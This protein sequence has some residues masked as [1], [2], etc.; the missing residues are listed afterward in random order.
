MTFFNINNPFIQAPNTS[1][2]IT[3]L[4]KT[5]I[6]YPLLF[7][8]VFRHVTKTRVPLYY[9]LIFGIVLIFLQP[10]LFLN[11]IL[12]TVVSALGIF[13]FN[14]PNEERFSTVVAQFGFS[15]VVYYF[16]SFVGLVG[17][18][19]VIT[20][21][22][23]F[24]ALLFFFLVPII[25]LIA[26][27]IIQLSRRFFVPYF[28]IVF[29]QYSGLKYLLSLLFVPLSYFFY[30][31][32]YN[33]AMI[34]GALHV[35]NINLFAIISATLYYI[36]VLTILYVVG[37]LLQGRE[38]LHYA[39]VRLNNLASYTSQLE[40]MY[41]DMRRFKHDYKN[42]LYSLKS[43]LD[44]DNL[45]YAKA[46]LERLT[47]ST[48]SIINLPTHLLGNLKN[49]KNSGIKSVVYG[50]INQAINKQLSPILEVVEPIDLTE[51]L[52]QIDAIRILSILLDNAINAAAESAEKKV[53]LC[54]Y[55]NDN[56]Q[57]IVVGNSTKENRI[58][59]DR[60]DINSVN[61]NLG[62]S[63]HIGLRNLRIILGKYPQAVNDRSS[64]KHWFEQRIILPKKQ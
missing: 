3:F 60:L 48:D 6:F 53:D 13:Y 14:N 62:A 29:Y 64:D 16:A 58:D 33:P 21:F 18:R 45:D 8:G 9:Y 41:D 39:Q 19:L 1:Y 11:D 50:K 42:V 4:I 25:Y 32:Q 54:L 20:N 10:N 61:F 37:R 52:A 59:L 22:P 30:L 34:S 17:A 5:I 44:T 46:E 47:D 55:E 43:A 27:L 57:F 28:R 26:L 51:T 36:L 40:V 49:I 63:H 24:S 2:L 38:E 31:F 12:F 15:L 35:K 7:W 23:Q 56:A